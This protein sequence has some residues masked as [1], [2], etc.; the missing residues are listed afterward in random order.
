MKTIVNNIG[1]GISV[2]ETNKRNCEFATKEIL[3]EYLKEQFKKSGFK[4]TKQT[5]Y[6]DDGELIYV[7]NVQNSQYGSDTFYFNIGLI[8]SKKGFKMSNQEWN[9]WARF[10]YGKTMENTFENILKWF[11]KYNSIDKIKVESTKPVK[12]L[13]DPRWRLGEILGK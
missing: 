4:K 11:E 5:W 1:D 13:T 9:C 10:P 7:F 3:L 2:V 6:K 12:C 8:F